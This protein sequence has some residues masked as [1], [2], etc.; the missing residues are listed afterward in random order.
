MT[1]RVARAGLVVPAHEIPDGEASEGE[2]PTA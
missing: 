2:E 1:A